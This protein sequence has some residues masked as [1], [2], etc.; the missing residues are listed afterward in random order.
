MR[1]LTQRDLDFMGIPRA[2]QE[3][4]VEG[5]F[6]DLRGRVAHL[7]GQVP[8]MIERNANI[9]I[10][11]LPG[12]GKTGAAVLLARAFRSHGQTVHFTSLWELRQQVKQN[13]AFSDGLSM[14]ERVRT[15][16]VL[17]LD[18]MTDEQFYILPPN[19]LANLMKARHRQ[20]FT[21]ILITS[22][23]QQDI[24][25]HPAVVALWERLLTLEMK[26]PNRSAEARNAFKQEF[27][28]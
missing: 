11:G 7:L 16:E 15:V 1:K 13:D 18:D 20:G 3:V 27:E 5:V 28:A 14:L 21:T 6:E 4:S 12:A 24:I 25:K 19:E 2:Y 22:M 23:S 9:L 17:V 8:R 10:H 26:G